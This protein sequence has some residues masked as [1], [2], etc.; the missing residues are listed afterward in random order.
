MSKKLTVSS[1]RWIQDESQR[2]LRIVMRFVSK[3]LSLVI[4][5]TLVSCGGSST[6][7][8]SANQPNTPRD[9]LSE[10]GDGAA[11]HSLRKLATQN[12]KIG[13]DGDE[14]HRIL[15]AHGLSPIANDHSGGRTTFFYGARRL[16]DPVLVVSLQR[17]GQFNQRLTDWTVEE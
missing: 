6:E 4:C 16:F 11:I 9:A 7:K 8:T 13:M 3:L 14:V 2:G 17:E 12:L 1:E 15:Q 5:L 10:A